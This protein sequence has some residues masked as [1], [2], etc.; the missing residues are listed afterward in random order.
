MGFVDVFLQ[1]HKPSRCIPTVL[2]SVKDCSA[3]SFCFRDRGD[4]KSRPESSI[5]P[6]SLIPVP[7]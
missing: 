7:T 6:R 1:I 3:N 2:S 5:T 4:E